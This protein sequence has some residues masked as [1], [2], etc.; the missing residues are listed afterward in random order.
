M[1]RKYRRSKFS[2]LLL[3][4]TELMS[5]ATFWH[6]HQPKSCIDFI[7]FLYLF[8][9]GHA[10]WSSAPPFLGDKRQ[11]FGFYANMTSQG[12]S[13]IKGYLTPLTCALSMDLPNANSFTNQI[14]AFCDLPNNPAVCSGGG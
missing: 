14:A 5:L 3:C 10:H 7:H 4:F 12:H 9:R 1:S 13:T 8:K 6:Y 11:C 2:D